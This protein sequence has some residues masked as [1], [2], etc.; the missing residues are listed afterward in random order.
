MYEMICGIAPFND[1]TIEKIFDNILNFRIMWP[2][3]G[4]GE[5]CMG[6]DAYDLITK[7][8]EPDYSKRLG[9]NSIDDIK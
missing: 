2:P 9:E 6:L 8:L 1:E 5:D 3:L 4:E 7:L